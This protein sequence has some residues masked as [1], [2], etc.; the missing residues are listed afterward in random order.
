MKNIQI[1][2]SNRFG[3]FARLCRW[4]QPRGIALLCWPVWT[5]LWLHRASIMLWCV[6]TIGAVAMRTLG[7]LIMIGVIKTLMLKYGALLSGHWPVERLLFQCGFVVCWVQQYWRWYACCYCQSYAGIWRSLF[8][9]WWSY[10]PQQN[11]GVLC[12]N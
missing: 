7:C 1:K 6:F 4:H 3:V 11:A 2:A 9:H 10:T 8:Y 5:V 12:L